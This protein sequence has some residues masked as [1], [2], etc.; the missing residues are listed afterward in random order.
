[1][2]IE[3]KTSTILGK[4]NM[5]GLQ[6]ITMH[7]FISLIKRDQDILVLLKNF[8]FLLSD[9]LRVAIETEKDM[10]ECDSDIDEEITGEPQ[11]R[12]AESSVYSKV[13]EELMMQSR[14][15]NITKQ[16]DEFR[17]N[18]DLQ[19]S[20]YK[21]FK[22]DSSS[23]E[24]QIELAHI[25]GFKGHNKRNTIK[26]TSTADLIS[27]TGSTAWIISRKNPS[28]P[29]KIFQSHTQEISCIAVSAD[30]LVATGE[31]GENPTIHVWDY[32]TL[33]IKFSLSGVLK[34]G[35]SHLA[36]SNDGKKLAAIDSDKN[37]TVV[38]YNLQNLLAGKAADLKDQ[39]SGIFQ[40]P[41]TVL[42]T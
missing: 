22:P 14:M 12:A 4:Y 29:Q 16:A 37:H 2:E 32:K 20:F 10:V 5:Q 1:M 27:I 31:A 35:V 3:K 7:E 15:K 34:G 36:F 17:Q 18:D 11:N 23:P 41:Q 21:G 38:V 28:A 24:V 30:S 6:V 25:S 33:Q 26:V 13:D 19:P 39:I 8:N 40:G 42:S 9:D